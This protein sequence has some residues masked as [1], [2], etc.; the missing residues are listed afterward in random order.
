MLHHAS[1]SVCGVHVL[2]AKV[3]H[4]WRVELGAS[5]YWYSTIWQGALPKFDPDWRVECML[6]NEQQTRTLSAS[7]VH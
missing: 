2:Y 1:K 6:V 3:S 4:L 5:F 7:N